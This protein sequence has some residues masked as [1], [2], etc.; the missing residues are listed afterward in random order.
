MQNFTRTLTFLV[1][2][3]FST[4]L[5][6]AQTTYATVGIIG[7]ATAK[8]WNESTPM[9][10]GTGTNAHQWTITLPL[11][12]D[13]V[14]FRANNAW[15]VNWGAATFPAGVGVSGGPNIPIA[16][17]GTY[18]VTF[19]DITG[20]YQFTRATTSSTTASRSALSLALAP[21]P[22]RETVR[23]AYDLSSASSAGIT[24]L[25][26]LGQPVRQLT[27]VRQGAGQQEQ[28][29]SLQNLAAGLYLVRVQAGAQV[30]TARLVVE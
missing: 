14:K 30:Q 23:V 1:A 4:T 21:N 10:A 27:A 12:K 25:N 15:D 9:T 29:V 28:F 26:L 6:M 3:L 18:T 2:L 8:G 20:A 24:V 13:E 19:N 5:A 7:S 11:T 16:E 17:A 22:T